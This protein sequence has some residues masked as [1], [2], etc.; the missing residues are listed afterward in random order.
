MGKAMK[1]PQTESGDKELKQN[2]PIINQS[3]AKPD[4]IGGQMDKIQDSSE[5]QIQDDSGTGLFDL[6][7]AIGGTGGGVVGGDNPGRSKNDN[8]Q[9][10]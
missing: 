1:D 4:S 6:G 2:P 3:D 10:E 8:D 7:V 9:L 5:N